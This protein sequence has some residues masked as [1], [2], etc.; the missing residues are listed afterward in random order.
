MAT[1]PFKVKALYDYASGHDDDLGF[2]V[3]QIITVTEEEDDDWY[4]GTYTEGSGEVKEGLFPKNFVEKYEPAAPP[5]PTRTRTKKEAEPAPPAPAAEPEEPVAEPEPEI[6]EAQEE[7]P[8]P[9]PPVQLPKVAE[10]P[11]SRAEEPKAAPEVKATPQPVSKPV[12]VSKP[13]PPATAEKPSSFRDRIAAFNKPAAAPVTPFKPS[14]SGGSSFIKKPFVAPPPSKNA[15][16]PP[17]RDIPPSTI[18]KRETEQRAPDASAE[19]ARAEPTQPEATE[20]EQPKATSLKE[21]IALLQK[22]QL[23]QQ[24]RHAEAAAKKA[25]PQRPPKKRSD[26]QEQPVEPEPVPVADLERTPTTETIGRKS[27]EDSLD[28]EA[29]ASSAA[30]PAMQHVVSPPLPSRELASDTNDADDSGDEDTEEAGEM[31]TGK[32]DTDDAAMRR[33][34][35]DQHAAAQ[36]AEKE[37]NDDADEEEEEEED[38]VDPE[39]KRRMEI[40][41]RMAKMSGGMGMMGMFGPPGGMPGMPAGG[42]KKSKASGDSQRKT[43]AHE[44]TSPVE[45]APPVPIMA[46]PGMSK[47]KSPEPV[48]PEVEREESDDETPISRQHDPEELPD[49]EDINN[50]PTVRSPRASMDRSRGPPPPVPQGKLYRVKRRSLTNLETNRSRRTSCASDGVSP[51]TSTYAC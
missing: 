11:I 39:I 16:V 22:Q 29:S 49:V 36:V 34:S 37:A 41:A 45:R 18:Y 23:E 20:E 4:F 26:P 30:I 24:A 2:A 6:E 48:G 47:V 46:L 21:R 25:K 17:P 33:P 15:Y 9:E 27:M 42:P 19:V 44:E 35:S 40:R 32:E 12:A 5:R 14:G 38:D 13:P 3:G 28:D 43:S 51:T 50:A 31:S 1:P 8:T 7:T 10:P